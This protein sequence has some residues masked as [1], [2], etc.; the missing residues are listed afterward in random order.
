VAAIWPPQ[1]IKRK[2][3]FM[4][5]A[6]IRGYIGGFGRALMDFYIAH[7]FV[8]NGIVLVYGLLV[9]LAHIS[10]LKAYR[11]VLEKL[12]VDLT[13]M[14]KNKP[15]KIPTRPDFSQLDW[16]EIGRT[17]WFPLIAAPRSLW[18]TLKTQAVL[19]HYFGE[20]QITELFKQYKEKKD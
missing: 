9:Y 1:F 7:S 19:E 20:A 3:S 2:Q 17:Y 14:E 10:Y 11:F 8:I 15:A 18:V 12:G 6:F 16:H 4:I 13:P 5:Y